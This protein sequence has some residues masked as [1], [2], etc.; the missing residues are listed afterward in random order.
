MIEHCGELRGHTVAWIG[1]G[2]NMCNSYL[3]AAIQGDFLVRMWFRRLRAGCRLLQQAAGRAVLLR[4]PL[5]AAQDA[6][7]VT[8]DVW[9]SM[10]KRRNRGGGRGISAMRSMPPSWPRPKLMLFFCIACRRTGVR[11]S[12]PK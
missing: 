4:D 1:D 6:D 10:G 9:S 11:K 2:N 8:T 3:S 5:A 7:V 12:A